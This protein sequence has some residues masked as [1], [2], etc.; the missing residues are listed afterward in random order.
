MAS[1]FWV[2]G[3]ALIVA[4]MILSIWLM[5]SIG[6]AALFAGFVVAAVGLALIALSSTMRRIDFLQEKLNLYM[7]TQQDMYVP[8]K[9]C[10]NCHQDYDFDCPKCPHCGHADK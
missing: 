2:V 4:S 9:N 10:P 5:P 1:F 7:P 3:T 6:A 8:Q